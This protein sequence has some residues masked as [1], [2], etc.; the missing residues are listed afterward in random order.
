[1][2]MECTF[3]I[4]GDT[5]KIYINNTLHVY[6]NEPIIAF[7]SFKMENNWFKIEFLLKDTTLLVEYDSEDKW[8]AILKLLDEN[9]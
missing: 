2:A 7:Q 8:L 5:R 6:F 3:K 4:L 9:L 1:M